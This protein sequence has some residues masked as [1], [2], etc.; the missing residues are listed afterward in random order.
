MHTAIVLP[1]RL[2]FL[3]ESNIGSFMQSMDFFT[4]TVFI[5]DIVLNFFFVEEDVNG[6][7]IMDQKRIAITYLKSWFI[8]DLIASFPIS[9]IMHFTRNSDGYVAIRFMKLTKFTLGLIARKVMT[10]IT[11]PRYNYEFLILLSYG[12]WLS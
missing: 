6:E 3:D 9:F 10:G 8:I 12:P 2:A 11:Q 5:I 7:M 4:D 1:I